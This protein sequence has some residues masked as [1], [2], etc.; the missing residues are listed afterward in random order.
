MQSSGHGHAATSYSRDGKRWKDNR[1][2]MYG[3]TRRSNGNHPLQ[4]QGI[5]LVTWPGYRRFVRF[6]D[7]TICKQCCSGNTKRKRNCFST[8]L[9]WFAT[10]STKWGRSVCFTF[11]IKWKTQP[12]R[13][14]QVSIIMERHSSSVTALNRNYIDGR[15]TFLEMKHCVKNH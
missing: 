3:M 10:V 15:D 6:W 14:R 1:P 7:Q 12:N 5:L 13:L 11:W 4:L 9:T 8:Q 2:R